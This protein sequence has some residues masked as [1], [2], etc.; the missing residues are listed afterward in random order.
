ML[1]WGLQKRLL[2]ISIY[3]L[4]LKIN[5]FHL[6]MYGKVHFMFK[7]K[8]LWWCYLFLGISVGT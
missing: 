5:C 2:P 4:T 1:Q 7:K 3:P 6:R 8:R